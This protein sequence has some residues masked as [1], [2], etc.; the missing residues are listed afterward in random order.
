MVRAAARA[1]VSLL[2]A[3]VVDGQRLKITNG[4]HTEPLWV[5]HMAQVNV[6]P[7]KQNIKLSPGE[8]HVFHTPVGLSGTRYWAKMGCNTTGDQCEIGESGGPGQSCNETIGCAPPVDTKFEASFSAGGVDWVDV[9]LVDG[10]TLPFKF[11]MSELCSAGDGNRHASKEVD[12]SELA[13]DSCPGA[14][15]VGNAS[16]GPVDLRVLNPS[17]G[18]VVG[19]LLRVA[20]S[21][22]RI[23]ATRLPSSAR[24]TQRPGNIVAP[25]RRRLPRH[26][27][28]DPSRTP[29]SSKPCTTNAPV[30]TATRTMTAWACSSAQTTRSTR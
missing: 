1:M 8:S 20:S 29:S 5:A 22:I 27:V 30:C 23:G 24:L 4:C 7:D 28:P 21:L 12:C 6:G 2:A 11:R 25:R 15:H 18:A 17:S 14:E 16:N 9:S 10:W 13:F 26:V 19:C 3:S